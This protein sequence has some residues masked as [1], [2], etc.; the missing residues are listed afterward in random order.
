MLQVDGV[1]HTASFDEEMRNK[2][3]ALQIAQV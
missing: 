2:K 3:G 1:A